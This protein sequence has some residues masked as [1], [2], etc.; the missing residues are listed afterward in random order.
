MLVIQLKI[1]ETINGIQIEKQN[2]SL[3]DTLECGQCFRFQRGAENTYFGVVNT[4]PLRISQEKNNITF[5]NTTMEDFQSFWRE[6]FDLDTD[7]E[8]IKDIITQD[9]IIKTACEH[10]GGIRILKQNSWEA[11]CS[12][13]I[14]QNNNIPR[15]Q[16]IIQ[17]LC[18]NFGEPIDKEC[19]SFPSP[20]RLAKCSLDDLA[21]LR[22]GFR[23]KYILDAAQK[24]ASEEVKFTQI[25]QMPLDEARQE[26]MKIKGVGIKVAD[27]ALL[28][29][30]YRLDAF[31]MDTWI[32]KA[33]HVFYKDGFPQFAKPYGGIAQQYIFHYIRKNPQALKL[34]H[35]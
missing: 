31:P 27:C 6:Y 9:S 23:G 4:K 22:A 13:I 14:S 21:V 7:Y 2:F 18:D 19:W 26:L 24:V 15:I 30:F 29:G 20:S 11:L 34:E 33:M 12:F 17:R 35:I 16:G 3:R 32:K 1:I 28:F 10:A 25:P 5:F 8:A